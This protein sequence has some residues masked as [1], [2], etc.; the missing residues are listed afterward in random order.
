MWTKTPK[1]GPVSVPQC[2]VGPDVCMVVQ[3]HMVKIEMGLIELSGAH[4]RSVS[5]CIDVSTWQ[6]ENST[7]NV[8]RS[9]EVVQPWRSDVA[10]RRA[11]QKDISCSTVIGNSD[12]YSYRDR[13]CTIGP[14]IR[15]KGYTHRCWWSQMVQRLRVLGRRHGSSRDLLLVTSDS[16]RCSRYRTAWSYI[17]KLWKVWQGHRRSLKLV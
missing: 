6:R 14:W 9:R 11:I 15:I 16:Q 1:F 7:S 5:K 4:W 3:S 13:H 10:D 17:S 12:S 8:S 2:L